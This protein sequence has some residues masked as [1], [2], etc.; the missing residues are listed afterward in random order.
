MDSITRHRVQGNLFPGAIGAIDEWEAFPWHR[1]RAGNCDTWKRH[2][3]QALAIDLFGTLKGLPAE[4]KDLILDRFA[5]SIGVPDGGS[6]A[7]CL[8]WRDRQ[9]ESA[10]ESRSMSTA[11][12]IQGRRDK[13]SG[14]D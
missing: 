9:S 2:S 14:P 8:E 11:E 4:I 7:V 3:S 12:P 6:W 5:Q 1:D 10:S 13:R